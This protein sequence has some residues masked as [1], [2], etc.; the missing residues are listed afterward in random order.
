[1][2][3]KQA[4][5]LAEIIDLLR[6]ADELGEADVGI[7]LDRARVHLEQARGSPEEVGVTPFMIN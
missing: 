2:S 7:C 3:D 5:L 6:V 4:H 1:M